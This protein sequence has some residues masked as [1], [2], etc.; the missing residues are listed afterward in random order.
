MN[1]H[2]FWK[3]RLYRIVDQIF[4]VLCTFQNR[5]PLAKLDS[6]LTIKHLPLPPSTPAQQS[7]SRLLSNLFWEHLPWATLQK[8]LGVI[9]ILDTGCGSGHYEQVFRTASKNRL[10]SYHG[11][12]V[13]RH[14]DWDLDTCPT[15]RTFS[16]Y[17]GRD[18]TP[19][20]PEH[21]NMFVSQS[22][23]EHIRNDKRY[24]K[25]IKQFIDAHPN[26]P[27]IQ[28]H[29]FPS[30]ACMKLYGRHGYRQYTPRTVSKI[31]RLFPDAQCFLLGLGGPSCNRVHMNFITKPIALD[32][33]DKR[34]TTPKDYQKAV[35]QAILEDNVHETFPTDPSFW[36]LIICSHWSEPFA[37]CT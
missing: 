17:S 36:A 18:I 32:G 30:S 26:R 6:H 15:Q 3:K 35:Q 19:H 11:L 4:F 23:I 34:K 24:F 20:I 21:T 7:P 9:R 31:T 16:L 10:R 2:P 5:R 14:P 8:N 25:S 33:I 22:A 29:L 13:Y 12:D 28:V 27:F 37:L 1:V